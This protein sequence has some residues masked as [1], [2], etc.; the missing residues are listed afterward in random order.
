ME[1]ISKKSFEE[2]FLE[3]LP[4]NL[5]ELAPEEKFAFENLK[6]RKN[7]I[8]IQDK[9]II[10]FSLT[11]VGEKLT[12]KDLSQAKDMIEVI[13]PNLIKTGLWKGKKFRRYDITS[14][15][16]RIYGGKRHFFNQSADYAKRVWLD[17]GFKEM[18]GPLCV[19]GF[20]NFDALF[21]AQDHPVRELHDTFFI[22]NKKATL[23]DKKLVEEVKKAHEGKIKGSKGWNY[24]WL[25]EPAKKV[26]L[27]THTTCLSARTL[28]EIQKNNQIPSKYFALGRC[29]R[30]ETVD[31][32]HLFEFNQ[33]EGIVIDENGN[34]QQLL[35]YLREFLNKM[36]FK[37]IRFR[38]HYFP[39]TEPSLEADVWDE[40]K[41]KW[42][43]I[44][45]AGIFR[46]EV[47][48]PIFGRHI[49]VLAWGYGF[50]RLVTD[51]FQITDLRD[52]FG[53]NINKLR[54]TKFW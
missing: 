49:P 3:T 47:T 29:F 44:V 28:V 13:T 4:R 31:Q 25:E 35:G 1:E 46:P 26:V 34:L 15:V 8:D 41:G 48:I 32:G 42:I 5:D 17:M 54:E 11:E 24:K 40:K 16:P 51:N 33:S 37:K 50:D 45:G 2:K 10:H 38:P 53:N 12:K 27:R 22:K 18:T 14:P 6:S 30:N 43:E 52:I 39:Y 36:G 20:W 21:T 23:P 9:K 19:S 7:I